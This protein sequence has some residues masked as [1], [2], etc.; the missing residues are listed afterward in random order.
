MSTV[1]AVTVASQFA[2]Y[3]AIGF[4]VLALA[5]FLPR[6]VTNVVSGSRRQVSPRKCLWQQI[7]DRQIGT[8]DGR[9]LRYVTDNPEVL[10]S[11]IRNAAENPKPP[12][13]RKRRSAP[14]QMQ[15]AAEPSHTSSYSHVASPQAISP[16]TDMDTLL[17]AEIAR[18]QSSGQHDVVHAEKK[19]YK[20]HNPSQPN[21]ARARE[22]MIGAAPIPYS[23]EARKAIPDASSPRD[24]AH[25]PTERR[26][27]VHHPL[28]E[29]KK[30]VTPG[31]A[32]MQ[33]HSGYTRT[34]STPMIDTLP[35]AKQRQI[36]SVISGL[37]GSIDHL[38]KQLDALKALLG[39]DDEDPTEPR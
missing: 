24:P 36:F 15:S 20:P 26:W 18:E 11:Y 1:P 16:G 34:T 2:S 5:A 30:S 38:K 17:Q 8:A 7:A 21:V 14:S 28:A 10:Q 37:Q 39:I 33:E 23:N 35:K 9:K 12:K 4:R 27:P 19:Q 13:K 31:Y 3:R 25:I 6:R 29:E 22:P 32:T